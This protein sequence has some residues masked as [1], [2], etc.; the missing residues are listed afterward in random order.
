MIMS[1]NVTGLYYIFSVPSWYFNTMN[2]SSLAMEVVF[3]NNFV[4]KIS[5]GI[6]T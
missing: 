4:S 5:F 2:W 3:L 1:C 6:A